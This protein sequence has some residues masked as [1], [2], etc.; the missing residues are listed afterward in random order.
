MGER[1]LEPNKNTLPYH[2]LWLNFMQE[3]MASVIKG[4]SVLAILRAVQKVDGSQNLKMKRS[5]LSQIGL[6]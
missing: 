4:G 5:L 6:I 1:V 3:F 2:L